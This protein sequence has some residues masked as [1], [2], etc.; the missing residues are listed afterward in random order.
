MFTRKSIPLNSGRTPVATKKETGPEH[1]GVRPS[2]FNSKPCISSSSRS[3]DQ[4]LQH[5]GLPQGSVTLVEEHGTTD[6]ASSILKGFAALGVDESRHQCPTTV[7]CVGS[8]EYLKVLPG[9]K[10][11]PTEEPKMPNNGE[12]MKIAWRYQRLNSS[13]RDEGGSG[14]HSRYARDLTFRSNIVPSAR[15]NE[16]RYVNGTSL[17]AIIAKL[18][19]TL[20]NLKGVKRVIIPNIL[21]PALY[22]AESYEPQNL[23]PFF[24]RLRLACSRFQAT[25]IIS[26]PLQLA[27]RASPVTAAIE[28]LVDTCVELEPFEDQNVQGFLHIHRLADL[29]DRGAMVKSQ[30]EYSFRVG[31]TQFE[32]NPWAIPVDSSEIKGEEEAY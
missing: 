3:L 10:Q 9:V 17:E 14:S 15:P 21:H 25:C 32:V 27:P 5:G 13:R 26:L 12:K 7:L 31:R 11:E 6:F 24:H 22:P 29:S 18:E 28:L 8:P 30:H 19:S 1:F 20:S 4:L 23:V 2:L 16:V